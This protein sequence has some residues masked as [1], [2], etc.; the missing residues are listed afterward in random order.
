MLTRID[1]TNLIL[2]SAIFIWGT[3]HPIAKI[4]L[5]ELTPLQIGMF[6]TALAT[7]ILMP[8]AVKSRQ[9][10]LCEILQTLGQKK[11]RRWVIK[12]LLLGMLGYYI[13][14]IPL[15]V[16]LNLQYAS[17]TAVLTNTSP[18][19]VVLFSL[20]LGEHFGKNQAIGVLLALIGLFL[21]NF[22]ADYT[23]ISPESLSLSLL[24]AILWAVYTIGNRKLG[25]DP[26]ISTALGSFGSALLFAIT[27]LLTDGLPNLLHYPPHTAISLLYIGFF[28]SGIAYYIWYWAINKKG[29]V[30]V[31]VFGYLVPVVGVFSSV[32]LLKETLSIPVAVGMALIIL[33][34][35]IT[36]RKSGK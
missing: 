21:M 2:L 31:S 9:K 22:D 29:V 18:L 35:C 19:F 13:Y 15:L 27:L 6:R 16:A 8:L 5:G 26:L 36:S 17:I 25:G 4:V 23:A 14:Q 20:F 28:G 3:V 32:I 7:L 24:T 30:E 10:E 34:V 11:T 1:Y 33:G 12:A